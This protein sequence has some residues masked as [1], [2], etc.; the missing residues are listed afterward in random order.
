MKVRKEM[1]GN[2]CSRLFLTGTKYGVSEVRRVKLA[3]EEEGEELLLGVKH[4]LQMSA[5]A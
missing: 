4:L 1:E 2:G 3:A 5:N